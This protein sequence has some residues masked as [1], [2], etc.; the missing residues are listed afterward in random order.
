MTELRQ[1]FLWLLVVLC[2]IAF[3]HVIPALFPQRVAKTQ[4][5]ANKMPIRSYLIG[6]VNALFFGGVT[7][8]IFLVIT[9]TGTQGLAALL[10]I[11]FFLFLLPLL[12]GVS[13]GWSAVVQLLSERL[14]FNLNPFW[15]VSAS[16]LLLIL[17]C[18]MPL[19]GWFVLTPYSGGLGLGAFVI[20]FFYKEPKPL[21]EE[22]K[23]TV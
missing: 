7:F 1:F 6:L 9:R 18:S 23:E 21:S 16:A 8:A 14:A 5:V 4:L 17:G 13:F 2:I 12:V 15:R 11:P 10:F 3:F 22:S 20:S 19:V